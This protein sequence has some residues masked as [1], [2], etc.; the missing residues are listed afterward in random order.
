MYWPQNGR[1]VVVI[2]VGGLESSVDELDGGRIS[3]LIPI[4][5]L[6]ERRRTGS[7][8][9]GVELAEVGSGEQL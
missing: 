4:L 5:Q 1:R 9:N 8:V 6:W 2:D 7:I 3:R